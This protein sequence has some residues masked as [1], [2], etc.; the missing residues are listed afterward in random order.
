MEEVA[1]AE[2]DHRLGVVER[3]K[4]A[5]ADGIR[6][7]SCALDHLPQTLEVS[8][9]LVRRSWRR[10]RRIGRRACVGGRRLP[11]RRGSEHWRPIGR[12]HTDEI[13]QDHPLHTW[14]TPGSSVR[15]RLLESRS[16]RAELV[17]RR[18]DGCV[19]A[20]RASELP[21]L[22]RH[23]IRLSV[24]LG[25]SIGEHAPAQRDRFL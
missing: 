23:I 7:A 9:T 15:Q 3:L 21:A 16:R 1:A 10:Q 17:G 12:C 8:S 5:A 14:V 19:V 25:T 11:P 24:R 22:L 2:C 20:Q 4:A 13:G 6:R 18:E